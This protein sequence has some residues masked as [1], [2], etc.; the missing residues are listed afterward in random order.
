MSGN[1]GAVLIDQK[2]TLD[3]QKSTFYLNEAGGEGGA[4]Y[5]GWR[6]Y[7]TKVQDSHFE[8]NLSTMEGENGGG[9]VFQ[10]ET[11]TEFYRC[12]F[13]YPPHALSLPIGSF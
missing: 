2:C 6:S 5:L 10:H 3:V 13:R 7:F 11:K 9:A 8:K 12:E 4:L 1:G